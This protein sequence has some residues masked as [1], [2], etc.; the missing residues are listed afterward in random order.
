MRL[1]QVKVSHSLRVMDNVC[2]WRCL[3]YHIN[4]SPGPLVKINCRSM[5]LEILTRRYGCTRTQ[6]VTLVFSYPEVLVCP[7][8]QPGLR[9]QSDFL[10][11]FLFIFVTVY[12]I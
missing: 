4:G 2:L 12:L 8:L 1:L 7:V 11:D 10:A 3:R 5:T 9:K 6:D